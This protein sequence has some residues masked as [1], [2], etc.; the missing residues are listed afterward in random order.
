[1][2]RVLKFSPPHKWQS[3]NGTEPTGAEMQS[4]STPE[5]YYDLRENRI[6]SRRSY[7]GEYLFPHN[8]ATVI[9]FL[10]ARFPSI[11]A[12]FKKAF[13]AKHPRNGV[14][15]KLVVDQLI[16]EYSDT[17]E[18]KDYSTKEMMLYKRKCQNSQI[19]NISGVTTRSNSSTTSTDAELQST[20]YYVTEIKSSSF[21]DTDDELTK[22]ANT[23]LNDAD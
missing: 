16:N 17:F 6:A 21:F 19:V 1:M 18:K 11:R 4:A 10:D 15:D 7:A 2:R 12:M 23:R 9:K 5:A 3:Y 13:E 14:V 20:I 8:V 22:I